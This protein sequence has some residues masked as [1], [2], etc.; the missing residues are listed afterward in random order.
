MLPTTRVIVRNFSSE[1]RGDK[2]VNKQTNIHFSYQKVN[3]RSR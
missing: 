1:W 3:A 2:R